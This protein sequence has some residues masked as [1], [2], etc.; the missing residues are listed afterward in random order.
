[1]SSP[2]DKPREQHDVE[3]LAEETIRDLEVTDE[4]ARAGAGRRQRR[5]W[6][7]GAEL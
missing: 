7:G 1:M 4:E 3:P 2:K 6:N 5:R